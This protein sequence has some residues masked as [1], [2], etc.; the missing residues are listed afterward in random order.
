MGAAQNSLLVATNFQAAVVIPQDGAALMHNVSGQNGGLPNDAPIRVGR[1]HYRVFTGLDIKSMVTKISANATVSQ[2]VPA[3]PAI[4][5]GVNGAF[6]TIVG[7]ETLTI[8]INGG[9]A[10]VVTFLAGD[11]TALAIVNRING[12]PGLAGIAS[13]NLGQVLL[14]SPTTGVTSK[15]NISAETAAAG[16]KTG[17][18]PPIPR[19]AFGVAALTTGFGVQLGVVLTPLQGNSPVQNSQLPFTQIDLFVEDREP[20]VFPYISVSLDQ[21]PIPPAAR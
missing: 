14:T 9:P 19:G 20:E 3:Q 18:G 21:L 7:G 17:L 11:V 15:I 6:A 5:Q 12:T 10:I 13:V 4:I 1:S 8:S 16:V 2:N